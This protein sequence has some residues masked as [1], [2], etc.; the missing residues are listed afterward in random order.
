MGKYPF[1]QAKK[2]SYG[3][4]RPLSGV[5]YIV[6][7][8]T[9][10]DSKTDTAKNEAS[11]FH[12]ED[13]NQRNAGAHF[14][15]DQNGDV[16][17]TIKLKYTAWSVGGDIVTTKN[18]AA[19]LHG[20]CTNTNSVSI[21]LCDCA[22]KD[23]SEKMIE[24]VKGVI[25]YI[26]ERCPNAKTTVRHFDCTGKSCPGRMTDATAAGKKRWADFLE[27]IGEAREVEVKAPTKDLKF[28]DEGEQVKRLQRCLN[29]LDK[30]GLRVDGSFGPATLRAV[31]IFKAK[32][33]MNGKTG[34]V[35]PKTRAKIRAL[36]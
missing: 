11:Y 18:G 23:P 35:G 4:E 21:E 33:G 3:G 10:N 15:V 12:R 6:I 31:N 1:K 9:G 24:A 17:Q 8:Y 7:H 20:I 34:K 5:R 19:S 27:A 30:A 36:L 28:G 16:Y 14:F 2:I 13:G 25:S 32:H 26:R 29:K 22:K